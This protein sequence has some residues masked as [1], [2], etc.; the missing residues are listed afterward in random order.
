MAQ[1]C[2]GHKAKIDMSETRLVHCQD[3]M[4][5]QDVIFTSSLVK[6]FI[7]TFFCVL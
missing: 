1:M 5:K 7:S 2:L 3:V 6:K 4:E